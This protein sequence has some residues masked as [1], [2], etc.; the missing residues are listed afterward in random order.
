MSTNLGEL[1]VIRADEL[2]AQT[3]QTPG[4]DRRTAIDREMAG[5]QNLWVGSVTVEP[6]TRTGAHHHGDCESVVCVTGGRIRFRFGERLEQS[7]EAGTGDYVFI[8]PHVVHQE[9]N[10]SDTER[11]ESIVVRDCQDNTVVNVDLPEEVV[12]EP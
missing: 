1:R 7:V 3:S 11:V 4:M 2:S 8:P 6:G 12:R 10:S 5:A 9:I